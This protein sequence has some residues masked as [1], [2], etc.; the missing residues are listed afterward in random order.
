MDE[1]FL[2]GADLDAVFDLFDADI[3]NEDANL[4][5]DVDI[6]VAD[7]PDSSVK[8]S[9]PCG[10]CSKVCLTKRGLSRHCSANHSELSVEGMKKTIVAEEMLDPLDFKTMLVKCSLKL[11]NDQCYSEKVRDE[12]KSY[13]LP[14]VIYIYSFIKDSIVSFT[15]NAEK[16]YPNFYKCV[17]EKP[18]F[19]GLSKNCSL[20]LGFEIANHV[21]SHLSGVEMKNDVLCLDK[22][23]FPTF[24]EKEK[25]IITYLSG[26][27]FGTFYRR[28]SFSSSFSN[29]AF[30][31]QCISFLLAGQIS[32]N[33]DLPEHS[34]VKAHDRGGLWKVNA[35]IVKI[36]TITEATLQSSTKNVGNKIY[37][38]AIVAH[39][40]KDTVLLFYCQTFQD[41]GAMQ[42]TQ[43]KKRSH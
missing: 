20:L 31:Q 25:S 29:N 42:V 41:L 35:D 22:K 18:L 10:V 32:D 16:F 30:E 43:S 19:P 36:F 17:S 38:K 4:N 23:E 2:T 15:G 26:Y 39:L 1:D 40:M 3:L 13:V 5:A 11:E 21:L 28:I 8:P 37:S 34:L 27:I 12:L 14:D 7:I 9:F 33:Q 24:G 6:V